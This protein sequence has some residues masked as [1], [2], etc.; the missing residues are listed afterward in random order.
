MENYFI[1]LKSSLIAI[2]Q[3]SNF[4]K[5]DIDSKISLLCECARNI[6]TNK[7]PK[8]SQ[9]FDEGFRNPA[10]LSDVVK[11]GSAISIFVQILNTIADGIVQDEQKNSILNI[12]QYFKSEM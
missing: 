1:D 8:I 9:L 3:S 12:L 4:S 6:M 7:E 2:D 5:K 11:D 10:I